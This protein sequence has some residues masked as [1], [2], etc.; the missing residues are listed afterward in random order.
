MT[1]PPRLAMAVAAS[2]RSRP[3]RRSGA[4]SLRGRAS[5][6]SMRQA[7]ASGAAWAGAATGST[8]PARSRA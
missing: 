1:S 4:A 7:S 5:A 2:S 8:R 6:G 3:E